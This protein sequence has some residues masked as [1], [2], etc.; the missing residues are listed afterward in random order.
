MTGPWNVAPL[1]QRQAGPWQSL[2]RVGNTFGSNSVSRSIPSS[3]STSDFVPSHHSVPFHMS[4]G[5]LTQTAGDMRQTRH[6][7]GNVARVVSLSQIRWK[8]VLQP[9]RAFG[10]EREFWRSSI[11]VCSRYKQ[12]LTGH[13]SLTMLNMGREKRRFQN[14]CH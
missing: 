13:R 7:S 5:F 6:P 1:L 8:K 11:A 14:W 4:F 2:V 12:P 9:Q 10:T 3:G